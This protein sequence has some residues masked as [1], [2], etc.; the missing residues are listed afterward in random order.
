VTNNKRTWLKLLGMLMLGLVSSATSTVVLASAA[1][2]YSGATLHCELCHG[3]PPGTGTFKF[4]LATLNAKFPLN[5]DLAAYITAGMPKDDIGKCD[6]A[7]GKAMADYLRPP[8]NAA[9]VANA[10]LSTPLTGPAPLVVKFD[11]SAST[12]DKGIVSYAWN[13]GDGTSSTSSSPKVNHTYSTVNTYNAT[14]T[15]MDTQGLK[16]T[17]NPALKIAVTKVKTPP[18][19]NT[20]KSTNLTGM[21]PLTANFDATLSTCDGGCQYFEWY[22]AETNTNIPTPTASYTFKT[23]GTHPVK[24]YVADSGGFGSSGSY[25]SKT[26]NVVVTTSPNAPIANASKSPNLKG[27]KPLNAQFDGSLSNCANTCGTYS[28]NFG[29]GTSASSSSPTISHAYPNVGTYTATLTVTDISNGKKSSA[30]SV[31]VTV[32]PAESLTSYVQACQSQLGFQNIS[33]PDLNCYDGELFA[34]AVDFNKNASVND[35]FGY[36]KITDQVDLAFACRWLFGNKVDDPRAPISIEMLLH[37]RQSG[38]TCFFSAKGFVSGDPG[39]TSATIVSPTGPNA[40][41]FWDAPASVDA[42]V[43]CIGCH[44]SGPYIATPTIAPFLAKYGLLNNGHDT[45]SNV[46]IADLSTPNKNVKYHAISGTVNGAPG[47]FSLWDSLKQSYIHPTDSSCAVGCHMVGTLSPQKDIFQQQLGPTTILTNPAEELKEINHAGVMKPYD[48][49]SDYRWINLDTAGDGVE[50]ETFELANNATTTLVPKLFSSENPN[51]A[52]PNVPNVMEAHVVGSDN[53]FVIAQPGR[54]AFLADRM[55]VFNLKQGLVCLNSDQDGDQK[56]RDYRVRYECTDATGKKTW[57]DYTNRAL[58]T[59]GDHEE[60]GANVCPVGSTATSIEAAFTEP[61]NGWTYGSKGPNDKLASFSQYGL[62]CNNADQPDGQCSNYVVRYSSCVAPPATV[63]KKLTNV[64][65]V[66]KELTATSN[67]LVKGQAH[68]N[69]WNT[70][71]W[72]IEP[73]KNTEYVRLKNTGTNVYLNV[74][75]QSES[76]TVGTASFNSTATGQMWLI[77]TISGSSDVRL[78]NVFSGKYLTMADPVAFP[79]TPDFLPVYSQSRNTSWT[80]QRWTVQ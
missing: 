62:T 39:L 66:G 41:T 29:D 67:S 55:S 38:N 8:A 76:A 9:P 69:S 34:V 23:V 6:V 77:E 57:T 3:K 61:S 65:A 64:F 51:C 2:D 21:A 47:A 16:H 35:F 63:N 22:I 24:V 15:V 13:F 25:S 80:S 73:I 10:S 75:S 36:R 19:I 42:K 48:D 53:S 1:E 7:C 74:S 79:S 18:V 56:C 37:N 46:S 30:V 54:F 43:R 14:L 68:N 49:W 31:Q 20:S 52:Q 58:K 59:D 33:I 71:Q 32:V 60:R 5:S 40:A 27:A 44:V 28:W 11:G 50:K 45:L 72:S 26:I 70:Q 78:K 4:T 17:T 12:D